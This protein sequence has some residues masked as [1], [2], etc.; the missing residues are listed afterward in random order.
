MHVTFD[1]VLYTL[2]IWFL[3]YMLVDRICRCVEHGH[4]SSSYNK[5]IETNKEEK[6]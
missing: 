2:L 5:A 4:I 6:E 3:V 1:I